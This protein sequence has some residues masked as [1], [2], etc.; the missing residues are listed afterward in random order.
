[1][2]VRYQAALRPAVRSEIRA[3][4]MLSTRSADSGR[5]I[6]AARLR[7]PQARGVAP[8]APVAPSRPGARVHL[9]E[10]AQLLRQVVS[11]ALEIGGVQPLARIAETSRTRPPA[12]ELAPVVAEE[13]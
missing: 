11:A 1:M 10:Q 12:R 5:A 13:D 7:P 3:P 4:A 9:E 8:V 2:Q 6:V